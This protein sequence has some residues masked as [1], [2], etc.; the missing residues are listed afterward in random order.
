MGI[1]RTLLARCRDQRGQVLIMVAGGIVGIL[2]FVALSTDIGI[3]L[4][5]S[6]DAQNDADAAAL[7]GAQALMLKP[8][9]E[10]M[11]V[12]L[13]EEWAANNGAEAQVAWTGDGDCG[14]AVDGNPIPWGL[15]D[16]NEDGDL[17]TIC[18]GIERSVPSAFARVVGWSSFPVSRRASARTVHAGAG[19]VCP[20]ALKGDPDAAPTEETYL[21]V[22]IGKIYAVKVGAGAGGTGNFGIL[23]LYPEDCPGGGTACYRG[24]IESGCAANGYNV[25]EEGGVI[26]TST[27][28]GNVGNPTMKALD[29]YFAYESDFSLCD[30][31]MDWDEE[32]E[33]GE[34]TGYDPQDIGGARV[35]CGLDAANGGRGRYMAIPIVDD[36]P[37]SGTGPVEILAIAAV[38]LTG[39]GEWD[40]DTGTYDRHGPPG[41]SKV[42]IEFLDK[43]PYDPKDLMGQSDNPLAPMR[44]ILIR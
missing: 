4:H 31:P 6:R 1:I 26:E 23:R 8:P 18:L 27:E 2:G 30:V 21:G 15:S 34:P 16:S 42:Y 38:Y 33:T 35:G 19:A 29:D 41:Q 25:V 28:P 24:I 11:A 40:P 9:D 39:W 43:A 7:A 3:F 17:D 37:P 32:T 13:A 22:E 20:W 36:F 44:I 12:Q 14:T 5:D 10:A